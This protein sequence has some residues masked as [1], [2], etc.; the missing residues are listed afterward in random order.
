MI[1]EKH[2][3]ACDTSHNSIVCKY[4]PMSGTME[5]ENT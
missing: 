2:A 5:W 4:F 3:S 1:G